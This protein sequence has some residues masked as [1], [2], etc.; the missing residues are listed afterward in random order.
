MEAWTP[1]RGRPPR[2]ALSERPERRRVGAGRTV[3]PAGQARRA[4]TRGRC[5][6]GSQRHLLRAVD[7]LPVER[8]AEGSAAQID[9]AQLLHAVGVGRHAGARSSRALRC[10]AREGRARGQ[11]DGGGDR[12]PERQSGT[13]RG[14]SID[15]QGF[16]A[17]K[18]VTGRKRHILVD[19]LGLLLNVV[20]H[21]ADVQDRDGA[22]ELLRRSRRLFPFVERIFADG[23]YRGP[24]MAAAVAKT[25]AWRLQIVKRTDAHRFVVLPKRWVVERTFAWISPQPPARP[26]FRALRPHRR[27]LRP[28]RH[29]PHHAATPDP[30]NPLL[31]NSNFI[32]QLLAN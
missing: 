26:R 25:G 14:A 20:V 22:V 12:Q 17:G 31:V 13:K 10:G 23:G 5:P 29:D 30:P 16:D 6:R 11:P 9:G 15:P 7:G 4:T 28:P 24:K 32:D 19:T 1:R 21:P 3:D 27:R 8:V 18:K 2:P